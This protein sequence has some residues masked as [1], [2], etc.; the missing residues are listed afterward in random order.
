MVTDILNDA[1]FEATAKNKKIEIRYLD[2]VT[3]LGSN[4]I[5]RRALENIIRNALRY[6]VHGSSVE[7]LQS[8]QKH[9]Q[10]Q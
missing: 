8:H 7:F 9:V 10:Y 1:H 3:V 4:E 6:T 5:L 2:D